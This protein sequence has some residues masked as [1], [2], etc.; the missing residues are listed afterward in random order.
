MKKILMNLR[1]WPDKT[2]IWAICVGYLIINFAFLR[3]TFDFMWGNHDVLFVKERLLLDSGL[4]EGRFT[5][6]ILPVFLTDGQILPVV[7]NLLGFLFLVLGLWILAKYWQ[8]PKSVLD[9]A[10]FIAFFGVMPYTLSWL[11]FTFIT[12]SCLAWVFFAALGLYLSAKAGESRHKFLLNAVAVLCF[13]LPLGGYPP[14]INMFAVVFLGRLAL[15]ASFNLMGIK[16]L[17][18]RY[19]YSVFNMLLALV[20]FK[21]SLFIFK[22]DAVYNL[23]MTPVADLPEKFFMCFKIAFNQFVTATPFMERGYKLWLMLMC[24]FG[25]IGAFCIKK[26]VWQKVVAAGLIFG[27]VFSTTL[28]TFLAV[29]HTEYVSRIDFYGIGFLYLLGLA[30]LLKHKMKFFC[31]LGLVFAGVGIF[32]SIVNDYRALNVWKKGNEAEFLI[33]DEVTERIE[34]Q[35][36]FKRGKKYRFY[37]IG[38]IALRDRYYH[39]SFDKDDVFL[40]SLPYLA[41]WQGGRLLEFYMPYAYVDHELPLLPSDITPEVY[42]FFMNKAR[43]WPDAH[44]VFVNDDIIIVVYHAGELDLFREKISILFH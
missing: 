13:Y 28:T 6:F 34:R 8:V 22:P 14:V 5:Q 32:L 10:V 17:W 39:G 26:D 43:P 15:E 19:K 33:L 38:D 18:K 4:F 9:Y 16:D 3:H 11:Y 25:G 36:Q 24:V 20:L 1:L 42:E 29:A 23:E 27:A 35:P 31:S 40:L 2:D 12:I 7:T 44:S 41:M 30:F 37:Q 21:G